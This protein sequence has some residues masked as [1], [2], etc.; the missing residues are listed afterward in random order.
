MRGYGL[1]AIID[2]HGFLLTGF[3]MLAFH[4]VAISCSEK[5]RTIAF[6]EALGFRKV[7]DWMSPAGDLSIVHLR[8]GDAILEIFNYANWDAPPDAMCSLETDL[9]MIGTKHFGLKVPDIEAARKWMI[10]RGFAQDPEV[11]QGRT[12]ISYFFINDPDGN[13]V[14]IVQDDRAL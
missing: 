12:G 11:K 5:E 1:R 14:E 9:P 10:A 4:H 13:W 3:N 8:L 6:Y 7:V 2:G